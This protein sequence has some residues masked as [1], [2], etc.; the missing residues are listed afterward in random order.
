[1][2]F[3]DFL[4]NSYTLIQKPPF[5]PKISSICVHSQKVKKDSL[6]IAF[7]GF[8]TDGH[9][10][11]QE[12][13]KKGAGALLLKETSFVPPSFEGLV[14]LYKDFFLEDLLNQFYDFPS[15]KLFTIGITGTN[16]KTSFCYI[17]EHLFKHC[18]WSTGIIGTV[19]HHLNDRVWPSSLTTPV[20]CDLFK[21]ISDFVELSA[22]ATVMEISSIALDQGRTLGVDFNAL[23]FSNL[24]QDHLDYHKTMDQYFVAKRKLFLQA[25]QNSQKNLFYLLNQDDEYSHKIKESLK[26]TCWTFGKSSLSDF[27][28]CI[29]ESSKEHTIFELKSSFGTYEFYSPLLGEYNVYNAVSAIACAMLVGFKAEDCQKAL[30]SFPGVPGRLEAIKTDLGFDIFID[31]AHT[32]QALFYVLKAL[33]RKFSFLVLVFGC[34]GERDKQKRHQMMKVALKFADKVFLTTDNPRHEDPE[35]IIKDSLEGIS[36]SH[37]I[38]KEL[39]RKLAIEKALQFAKKSFCVLIAGKGHERFQIVKD[40]K[41][42]FSDKQVVLDFLKELKN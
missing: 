12:A 13:V 22:Q 28:F 41:K 8:K 3:Q 27:V 26:K 32:A 39:D 10:Y 29:K 2:D 5:F 4:L 37:K 19:D 11:I 36:L 6:F 25:E 9:F 35:E 30:Q 21:R 15:R 38:V 24:S 18:G 17:L 7:K 23:V 31:Y 16:G 33:K 20:A 42:P 34:G 14:L 40:Q 1:M